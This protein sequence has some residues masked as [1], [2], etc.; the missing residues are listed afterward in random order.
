MSKLITIAVPENWCVDAEALALGTNLDFLAD[1]EEVLLENDMLSKVFK[2]G[3]TITVDG[4][5]YMGDC[6]I[7]KDSTDGRIFLLQV[8]TDIPYGIAVQVA[9]ADEISLAEMDLITANTDYY[10]V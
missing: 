1:L 2:V 9:N 5:E 6:V 10:W 4:E 8:D 7:T 3:D